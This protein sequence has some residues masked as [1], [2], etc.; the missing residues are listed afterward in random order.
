MSAAV[1]LA[2]TS[3]AT[4]GCPYERGQD[5]DHRFEDGKTQSLHGPGS[6]P[7]VSPRSRR[8]AVDHAVGN[9]KLAHVDPAQSRSSRST[10]CGRRER[11]TYA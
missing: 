6:S 10:R 3:A 5:G 7:G 8:I 1:R 2:S 11:R 9:G 4:S